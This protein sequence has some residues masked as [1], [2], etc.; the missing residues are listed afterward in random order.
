MRTW[1]ER[2]FEH[3]SQAAPLK[4]L[5]RKRSFARAVGV[6]KWTEREGILW[7]L[8]VVLKDDECGEAKF[9]NHI[10]TAGW[11][12][13]YNREGMGNLWFAARGC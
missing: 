13:L 3:P 1:D 9:R 7:Y 2:L 5:Q 8:V 4:R 12:P 6:A 10:L 11:V